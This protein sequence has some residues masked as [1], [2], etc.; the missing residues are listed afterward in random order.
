MNFDASE[1]KEWHLHERFVVE[2]QIRGSAVGCM[3]HVNACCRQA[4]TMD[5]RE[6]TPHTIQY[7]DN[8]EGKMP[9]AKVP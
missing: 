5:F 4:S 2:R 9:Q 6:L 8:D 7:S 1:E 3:L